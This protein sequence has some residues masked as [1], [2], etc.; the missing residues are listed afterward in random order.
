MEVHRR[1]G[2]LPPD[3]RHIPPA[4]NSERNRGTA[5][6]LNE[7]ARVSHRRLA[8]NISHRRETRVGIRARATV[9]RRSSARVQPR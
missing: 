2:T 1:N 5:S 6:G 8:A 4:W 7:N 3:F 9:F